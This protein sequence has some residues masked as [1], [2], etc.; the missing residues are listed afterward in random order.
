MSVQPTSRVIA[1]NEEKKSILIRDN[2]HWRLLLKR[3]FYGIFIA[4]ALLLTLNLAAGNAASRIDYIWI[5]IGIVAIPLLFQSLQK[6]TA[7]SEIPFDLLRKI[8]KKTFWGTGVLHLH[9]KNDKVREVHKTLSKQDLIFLET[10]V[11]KPC[12]K[13]TE[14]WGCYS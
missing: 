3:L 7:V 4:N 5:A 8:S 6:R 1:V 2:E 12:L 11:K 13:R 14:P 9:L 10:L